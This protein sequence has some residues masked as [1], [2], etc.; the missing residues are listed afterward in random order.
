MQAHSLNITQDIIAKLKEIVPG[1]FTEDKFDIDQLKQLLGEDINTDNERYHLD[2]AGKAEAFK[3]LQSPTTATLLPDAE[4]SVDWENAQNILI[5][6]ENLEA[7]KALQKSYYGKVKM[8]YIDPPYN[9]GGDSFIYPDKFSE[10]KE[11]YLR[12]IG[13]KDDE[14]YLMK[15]GFF[16][17]NNKENG[18]FH[19]N[20]LN[21]MMPRLFLARNLLRDDG[22]I[23]ISIDD[24]EVHNLRLLM[25]EIFGE[26]NFIT[27]LIWKS[28]QIVDSRTQNGVSNDHEYVIVFGKNSGSLRGKEISLDKYS[29]PDKDERGDWM[30][31]SILGLATVGQ[32]PNLHYDIINPDT[33][34]SYSPPAET[35][36]RYSKETMENKIKEKRIVFPAKSDGRPREKKFLSELNK[37]FTGFSSILSLDAGYTLNGTRET[38]EILDGNIFS[39]PKP[40][41]LLNILIE[42]GINVELNK[43]D[44]ILDF[45]AG[46]GTTAQAVM[47]LNEADGGNRKY[48]CIQLPE[49]TDESSE[50]Y[51]AGYKSI[52]DITQARI[53]KV[54]EKI[55]AQRGS[56]MQFEEKQPLG[57]RKF[58]LAPS[59]FK[60][61]RGDIAT[62]EAE[63]QKQMDLFATAQKAGAQTQNILW[64]L[65]LKNGMSLTTAIQKHSL[66]EDAIIYTTA[67]SRLAFVL[68]KYTEEVQP[69]LLVLRPQTAIFLDSLFKGQDQAKTNL[70][71]KLEESGITFKTI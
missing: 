59:N 47:E 37:S 41:S 52:A 60:L 46:S 33:G 27:S 8:I 7:L 49:K 23:F 13:D 61:W 4:A 38:R 66:A 28:R 48:I 51:K 6:G 10:T 22:V 2:W 65:L 19:S 11:E 31:N 17:K 55:Q 57:F 30:S 35:G 44:I 70:Q 40:V 20:W 21:M 54:I 14:G 64:E 26:E 3:V 16:R 42:Q 50:A 43:N 45:F 12:R 63:L 15:E 71:L 53:K 62:N 32:R 25:N 67:G 1:A 18:Q 56:E 24:N 9:T 58:T 36:W 69:K 5:E 68:D 34:L 39:F 29:N